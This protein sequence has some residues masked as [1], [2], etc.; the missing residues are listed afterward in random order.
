MGRDNAA[1][2]LLRV[3]QK[4]AWALALDGRPV[5]RSCT[6]NGSMSRLSLPLS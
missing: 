5:M 3:R 4:V 2:K 1:G 6:V